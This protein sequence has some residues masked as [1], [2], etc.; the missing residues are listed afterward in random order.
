MK[1]NISISIGIP[2]YNEQANIKNLLNSFLRQKVAGYVLSEIII[3]SDG[4]T[5]RTVESAKEIKDSRIKIVDGDQRVGKSERIN[6]IFSMFK[7]DILILADADITIADMSILSY[8]AGQND[9]HKSGIF[10]INARPGT[11]GS[12]FQKVINSGFLAFDDI[13]NKWMNGQNYLRFKG[14]FLV[15][16]KKFA[17]EQRIPGSAVNN[18][19]YLYFAALEKKYCPRYLK[20]VVVYFKSPKDIADHLGQSSRFKISK[21]EMQKYFKFNLEHEYH[22]PITTAIRATLKHIFINPVYFLSYI[23]INIYTSLT[24]NKHVSSLWS[25]AVSTK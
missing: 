8:I 6:Q 11:A 23:L 24:K 22:I 14:C 20:K 18:D 5:D 10:G 16:D 9:I 15:L 12:F 13:A 4:S 2:A 3:I 7:G 17:R 1:K 25:V 19:A 21:D